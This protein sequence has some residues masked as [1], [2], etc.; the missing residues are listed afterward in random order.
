[1]VATGLA[2]PI[3]QEDAM[4]KASA[5]ISSRHHVQ[6]NKLLK[7]VRYQPEMNVAALADHS[8]FYIFNVGESDGF[9]IVS[10]DDRF[11]PI[12]GYV[13]HG[14]FD[15]QSVPANMK[16]WLDG[17]GD[18]LR[19]LQRSEVKAEASWSRSAIAPLLKTQWNQ[20]EPFNMACP[21]LPNGGRPVT[22]CVPT[23]MAQVMYYHKWPAATT[24]TIADY[25]GRTNWEGYGIQ[26]YP[27]YPSGTRLE[28]EKMKDA[29][30]ADD[31][32]ADIKAVAR[33]MS[34]CGAS[35]NVDYRDNATGGSEADAEQ[36][37]TAFLTYFDYSPIITMEYRDNYLYADWL[38]MVYSELQAARPV[39]Y[40]GTSSGG[41]HFFIVDGCD[42]SLFH[43][44]WGWGGF[45]DGYFSL[46][47][48]NPG[49]NEGSGASTTLDGYGLDQIAIVGIKKN[50]GEQP[51]S[52][53]MQSSIVRVIG[54]NIVSS[55]FNDNPQS[56]RFDMG[57]GYAKTDGTYTLVGDM[58]RMDEPLDNG[59]GYNE[60]PFVV[61]GLPDGVYH[62]VPISRVVGK[63]EWLPNGNVKRDFVEANIS[64]GTVT[65]KLNKP[66]VKLQAT[67]FNC[68]G[69]H[70]IGRRQQVDVTIKNNGDEYYGPLYFF[71]GQGTKV[72]RITYAGTTIE[73]GTSTTMTFYYEPALE[74]ENTLYVAT[75]E[76]CANIVGQSTLYINPRGETGDNLSVTAFTYNND[77]ASE[78]YVREFSGNITVK[79]AGTQEFD[80]E[81]FIRLYYNVEGESGSYGYLKDVY[82]EA[83][84][85]AGGT[86]Q[87]PFHIEG[88][89]PGAYYWP[90]VYVNSSV[91]WNTRGGDIRR[92]EPDM[93]GIEAV[94]SEQLAV[95]SDVWY[96]L[97]G[98]K[99]VNGQW[100]IVNGKL[101]RGIYIHNGKKVIVQ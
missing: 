78:R 4:H 29:Y 36:A 39:I 73:A 47:I 71:A 21:L 16:A 53:H 59:W 7:A 33:L 44:N 3:S 57:I 68:P 77:H 2:A 25:L 18:Q 34:I 82:I 45:C 46:A 84:V 26:T 51:R 79:N 40:G 89:T 90:M 49:S 91:I 42:G 87:V 14:S 80:G 98:R 8:S 69:K 101:P 55:Y 60:Y 61:K 35:V 92:Y 28:W 75:D 65:L 24:A 5:F 15:A 81:L 11:Q 38:D 88:L 76:N 54:S 100:S 22:G 37:L 62:L 1:M 6:G 19:R 30:T 56:Y 52:V 66:V 93:V 96:D 13:D 95:D 20:N 43:V 48:A 63:D 64:G 41:A 17:Y 74:G 12:L 85:P 67:A 72:Y 83:V 32:E 97:S 31:S 70:K 23:A 10:G 27:G 94:D 99:I 50:E 86:A 9:V 58:Y